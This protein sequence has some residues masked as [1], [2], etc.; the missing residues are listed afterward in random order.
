[1]A[2]SSLQAFPVPYGAPQRALQHAIAERIERLEAEL[3]ELDLQA[4]DAE[5]VR[6]R[7]VD[8][9][10]LARDP[11]LLVDGQRLNRAHVVG[12]VRE[13]D[14]NHAQIFRHC[15]QHLAE[16]LG[17]RLCG[18]VEAQVID[19]AH[20]V[21]EQRDVVAEPLLYFCQ[22][23]ARVLDHVVQQSGFDRA[24]V[25]VQPGEDLGDRD[26]MG[27][28]GIAAAALLA[29]VRLRAELVRLGDRTDVG[30]RQVG[31]ELCD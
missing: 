2:E 13:L 3:L 1:M 12:S 6:D 28:V 14:E 27:D 4:V 10:R 21:D 30:V 24:R 9:E 7:C 11:A 16:A 8:V 18:A 31:F 19:L 29:A 22:R 20:A 17:L 15:E 25:E 5:P 26:R 23:A